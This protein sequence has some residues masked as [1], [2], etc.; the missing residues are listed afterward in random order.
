[1]GLIEESISNAILL[2]LGTK[3]S[4]K[5][6]LDALTTRYNKT[7]VVS[8]AYSAFNTLISLC[9]TALPPSS[10]TMSNHI[11]EFLSMSNRL[12]TLG[13]PFPKKLLPLLLLNMVPNNE[14]WDILKTSLTRSIPD[15]SDL[16][17]GAVE[18]KLTMHAGELEQK[19]GDAP[20]PSALNSETALKAGKA[21]QPH[22]RKPRTDRTVSVMENAATP[23]RIAVNS[24]KREKRGRKESMRAGDGR[25]R[26]GQILWKRIQTRTRIRIAI[27]PKGTFYLSILKY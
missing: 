12:V 7:N 1:M 15:G 18:S 5:E 27:R 20:T 3:S 2:S 22:S 10:S 26:I 24:P 16:T 13:F 4:S 14:N 23:A 19:L 17:L 25:G 9:Y 6:L 11:S 21:R 8:T